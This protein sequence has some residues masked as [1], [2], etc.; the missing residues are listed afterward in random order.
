[1][2]TT[3]GDIDLRDMYPLLHR[4]L[5]DEGWHDPR[6]DEYNRYG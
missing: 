1:L 3:D 2:P 4:A 6:M 5:H